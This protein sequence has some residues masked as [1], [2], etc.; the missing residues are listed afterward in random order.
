M[1]GDA[2]HGCNIFDNNRE[3][4]GMIAYTMVGT[5]DLARATRFYDALFAAMGAHR[6]MKFDT[7]IG[8]A[9]PNGPIFCVT[10][11]ANGDPAC[12]GNGSMVALAAD[13]PSRVDALHALAL[14]LGASDEG[15]PR[16]RRRDALHYYAGY[17]R[18]PD[19]NKLN[20]FC[21]SRPAA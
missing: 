12:I 15:A 4:Y 21:H 18:D 8:W 2:P 20:F 7:A 11:P 10:L 17:F 19:G 14:S 16:Q 6:V 1:P 3:G 9:K 5:N 13:D